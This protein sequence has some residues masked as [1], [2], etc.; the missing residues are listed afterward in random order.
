M[1]SESK[2]KAEPAEIP[3][4]PPPSAAMHAPAATGEPQG[5]TFAP[6]IAASSPAP[7][8]AAE[9]APEPTYEPGEERQYHSGPRPD[10]APTDDPPPP[11]TAP[12][13][14]PPPPIEP[15]DDP[16]PAPIDLP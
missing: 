4:T 9:A 7:Q 13:D 2:T 1:P 10:T 12:T 15:T 5:N 3:P 16:P 11:P 6:P 8:P 14:D